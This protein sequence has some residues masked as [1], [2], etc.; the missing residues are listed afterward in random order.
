M[1]EPIILTGMVL[2]CAPS[3]DYDRRVVLL[4]KERGKITAF[5]RGA[6]RQGSTLLGATVPFSFGTFK[7]FEGRTAYTLASAQIDQY[8]SKLKTDLDGSLYGFYFMELAEYYGRE[9]LDASMILNLLFVSLRAL[10]N[11]N[12]PN[13][14]V[15]YV[16]EIRLMVINGEYPYPGSA[17]TSLSEAALYMISYVIH[18]PMQKLY[19]FTVKPEVLDEVAALQDRIRVQTLDRKMKSLTMVEETERFTRKN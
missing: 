17:D 1:S 12:L 13:R 18:T 9:N 7:L 14:L 16:F 8:F 15:R 2:R 6:R 4:T 19:T 5:A 10:E 3:G 11:P